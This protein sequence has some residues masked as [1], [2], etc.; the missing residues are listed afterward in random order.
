MEGDTPPDRPQPPVLAVRLESAERFV[1]DTGAVIVHGGD[2]AY[3]KPSEGRIQLPPPEQFRS[4]EG[5][6][7]TA[8]HELT[9]WSEHK[10]RLE[11]DLKGRFGA[12]AYAAEE[13]VAKIGAAF[14]CVKA[15]VSAEPREDH[16]HYLKSWI[17]VLKTDNRAIF[18]AASQAQKAADYLQ[19]L[20][21]S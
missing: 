20:Q 4:S 8:L 10:S 19:G 9:H 3:Y 5:Y 13:L 7:A 15:G 17:A 11:R 12:A 16:A 21:P 14:L 18:T 6:Y 1:A 2:R